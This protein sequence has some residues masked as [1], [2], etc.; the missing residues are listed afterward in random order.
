MLA[1]ITKRASSTAHGNEVI[2]LSAQKSVVPKDRL[3]FKREAT[4]MATAMEDYAF[5]W[6][7]TQNPVWKE[8]ITD[9]LSVIAAIDQS[10]LYSDPSDLL[11]ARFLLWARIIAYDWGGDALN[12][13]EK[14]RL[15]QD[16]ENGTAWLTEQVT[17]GAR[18][19]AFNPYNSQASEV[20]GTALIGASCLLGEKTA[21]TA[22]FKA[23]FPLYLASLLPTVT[24]DGADK[25][26]GAYAIWGYT[27]SNLPTWEVL[28]W[29]SGLD[30]SGLTQAQRFGRWVSEVA[31]PGKAAVW[32]GDGAELLRRAEWESA[33]H[34][35]ADRTSDAKTQQH[36]R[37][38]GAP[39]FPTV[40]HALAPLRPQPA[41][42]A[43]R[44]RSVFF[45]LAGIAVLADE[46]D[47]SSD[48]S[49]HFRSSPFGALVHAH[50]DQNSFVITY[51]GK[52]L[53]IDSGSYDYWG[54]PHYLDWYKRTVAH[55]A[56][57]FDG[58]K[59]QEL[60]AAPKG[61]GTRHGKIS[62][63]GA[64][65]AGSFVVGDASAA[66]GQHV[67]SAFR[68]LAVLPDGLVVVYDQIGAASG[69]TWEWNLH[70]PMATRLSEK[71]LQIANGD[72][73]ACVEF[74]PE[75]D[76]TLQIQRKHSPPVNREWGM[77]S[78]DH[79]SYSVV[80]PAKTS[81]FLAVFKMDCTP[82]TLG[83]QFGSDG[84]KVSLRNQTFTVSREGV[85]WK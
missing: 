79:I 71:S 31:P 52:H 28:R 13:L 61:D 73:R 84:A 76:A 77:S 75:H 17:S 2:R 55:N 54:S 64:V 60:D 27:A 15:L 63:Q 51:K 39:R 58:G 12:P 72:V 33:I 19:L 57:T 10:A 65:P 29:A 37:Q 11:T 69:K 9:T 49:A 59:G 5:L 74:F 81:Q 47:P 18:G 68:T 62:K 85:T 23:L 80:S 78:H 45:D 14:K 83:V 30:L 70:T 38:L 36:A 26:A 41:A 42:T 22:W 82:A 25:S 66:Y 6:R 53:A 56:I 43:V 8:K 24:T 16:I 40:W 67:S 35:L 20:I 32:W 3:A 48:L 34:L 1:L 46:A 44:P 50:Y 7:F 21:A 4:R